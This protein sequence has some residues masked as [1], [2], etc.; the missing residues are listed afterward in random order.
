MSSSLFKKSAAKNQLGITL[1]EVLIT[2]V[3]VAGGLL[4]TAGLML[5]SM[6]LN[7]SGEFR[8]QAVLAASDLFE[9]MEANKVA[10]INGS[11]IIASNTS[12][13]TSTVT[14]C[15][16]TACNATS[17][18]NYDLNQWA[19]TVLASLPNASWSVTSP[20]AGSPRNYTVVINW[21]D[22]SSNKTTSGENFAYTASRSINN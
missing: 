10:A 16:S 18:A 15:T 20:T 8:T 5:Y 9:R 13:G 4:G 19:N 1:I 12:S 11:Y 7:K 3:I 6:K 17:L 2:L 14:N 22:R 21:T